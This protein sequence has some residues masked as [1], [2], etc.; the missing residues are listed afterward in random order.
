AVAGGAEV[1]ERVADVGKALAQGVHGGDEGGAPDRRRRRLRADVALGDE[2]LQKL[3]P[4]AVDGV[5][6]DPANDLLVL[7]RDR[8]H[9]CLRCSVDARLDVDSYIESFAD[10]APEL[11]FQRAQGRRGADARAHL[12]GRADAVLE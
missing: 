3:E 4:S 9:I 10:E 11:R 1:P 8:S 2:L 6:E 5:L 7:L 12:A